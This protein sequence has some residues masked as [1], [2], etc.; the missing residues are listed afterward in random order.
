[1]SREAWILTNSSPATQRRSWRSLRPI[2]RA[3]AHC[4]RGPNRNVPKTLRSPAV[5]LTARPPSRALYAF[6]LLA[7]PATVSSFV[8]VAN[9][10]TPQVEIIPKTLAV[11]DA[12]DVPVVAHQAAA[13]SRRR[14][15][16]WRRTA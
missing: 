13:G 6:L 4:Q 1:M 14:C 10:R 7:I 3:R 15:H 2:A 9:V 8:A 11:S 5:S 16:A 12:V